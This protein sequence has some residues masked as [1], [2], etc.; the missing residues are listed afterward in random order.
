MYSSNC[1]F[2]NLSSA[3]VYGNPLSL[4]IYENDALHPVSPYGKHKKMAEEI[5]AE[6]TNDFGLKTCNL[7][8]F[9]AYGAGLKK[10]LLWDL[11]QKSLTGNIELFG[12]GDE[13]RDFIY[14]DDLLDVINL[15][16]NKATFDATCLNVANG[17]QVKIKDLVSL[18]LQ[19]LNFKGEL[20]F[21]GSNRK[22]DPLNWE[23]DIT[24]IRSFGYQQNVSLEKGLEKYVEWLKRSV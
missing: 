6:F 21:I 24:Q 22:G 20:N 17:I 18:Y 12:T 10:Q 9:S 15:V 13:T 1:K 14:I 7:R 23:A 8:I 19:E 4:P 5:C 3:A 11:Y 2:I 16:A